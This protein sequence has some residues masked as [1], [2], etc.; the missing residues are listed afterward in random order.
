MCLCQE[1]RKFRYHGARLGAW[2]GDGR[3]A[4]TFGS[5]RIVLQEGPG[6]KEIEVLAREM[7]PFSTI[8]RNTTFS[9]R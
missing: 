6:A 1:A 7:L 8:I 4:E 5:S 9:S 2:K 3:A